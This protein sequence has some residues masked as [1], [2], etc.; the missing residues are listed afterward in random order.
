M[1]ERSFRVDEFF[2]LL[3][4]L[5]N[6]HRV[7]FD[8]KLVRSGL[9]PDRTVH[10]FLQTVRSLGF[11][12]GM[13]KPSANDWATIRLP[14]VAFLRKDENAYSSRDVK[15]EP[16]L[17]PIVVVKFDG[18]TFT[19][20]RPG[21]EI[22]ETLELSEVSTRLE[23]ELILF[24]RE[25]GNHLSD[26][27]D[28]KIPGFETVKKHF[29]FRWFI[30]ELLKHKRIWRDVLLAS[31]A[32][33]LVGLATPLFTQVIIDKVVVHQTQS[34]LIALGAALVMFM[35]LYRRHVYI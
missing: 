29:G 2:W 9:R 17:D 8:E 27:D 18:A 34:T 3:G 28:D 22:P 10:T 15:A 6:L 25:A 35:L 33:Q 16:E 21:S 7:P 11:R 20:F 30:P 19:C 4:S 14:F 12:V 1:Q 5:C 13:G 32:I 23:E 26:P 24:A 31:L